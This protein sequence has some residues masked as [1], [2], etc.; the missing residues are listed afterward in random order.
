MTRNKECQSIG[1]GVGVGLWLHVALQFGSEAADTD[2]VG[3][4][5]T[6]PIH[7]GK[8]L[9]LEVSHYHPFQVGEPG[10]K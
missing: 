2:S 7:S 5:E 8:I 3:P 1:Q 6:S 9:T 4:Q 10:P